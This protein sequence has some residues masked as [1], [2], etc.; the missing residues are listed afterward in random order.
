[1]RRLSSFLVLAVLVL[2]SFVLASSAVEAATFRSH[3]ARVP[4]T[5]T[6]QQSVRIWMDS[7]TAF[8]ETA[9]LEYNVGSSYVKVFATY[10]ASGYGGANWR[11]DI[12]A[13][14]NGTTV[15]YQLFTRNQSGADYGFTGFN[16]SYTVHDGDIQWN[17]LR[18]DTFDSYYRAPFGAVAAGTLGHPALPHPAARRGWSF[19]AR[20]PVQPGYRL[21][22]CRHRLPDDLSSGS[23]RKR[24]KLC[25]LELHADH[26]RLTRDPVL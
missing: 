21:H 1:M 12:P 26:P 24:H 7:D 14:S 20:L 3:V 18:H 17:G 5:P 11:A 4:D 22:L 9:G 15:R 8:G 6:S 16:W 10:D 19:R 25:D 23:G 2:S 13:Q